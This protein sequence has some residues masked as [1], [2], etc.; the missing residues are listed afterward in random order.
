MKTRGALLR[1]YG[2][3][4]EVVD[5]ELAPPSA[6]EVRLR[7]VASGVCRSDLSVTHGVLK[8]PFPVV[9]GHEGAGIVEEVGE[10]V[11]EVALGD[12]VVVALTPACGECLFCREGAPNRCLEMVP[13][14]IGSTMLDGTTR[15]SIN[16]ESVYQLCGVASFAEHAVVRARACIRVDDDVPLSRACLLGCGVLTGAGTVFN[17]DDIV[18]GTSL[19]VVGCGG[20]GLAA[21]QAAR[22]EGVET[23]IAVDIDP[24]KLELAKQL[25]A[26]HAIDAGQDVRKAIRKLT[27]LGVHAVIEAVGTVP[28]M[29]AAWEYLR[30]G[31][32]ELAVGMPRARDKIAIRA[33]GLFLEKRLF[34]VTYGGADPH[35]DIPKLLRHIRDGEFFIDDLVSEELPLEEAQAALDAL[36][37]GKGARQVI[38]HR[39]STGGVS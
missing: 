13:G 21:I 35:R 3:K 38:V 26:H 19:A 15:L 29:E 16:G 34:G 4:L 6:G 9:L 30:P 33:G 12:R 24:T 28:T 10:G 27:G 36:D 25:G 11:S 39:E 17:S 7:V 5:L 2:E 20:V 14:M 18:A 8:T 37:A 1:G 22:I 32:V 23:I 31:G